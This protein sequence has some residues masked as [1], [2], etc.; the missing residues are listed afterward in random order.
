LPTVI[1]QF[2]RAASIDS[3]DAGVDIASKAANRMNLAETIGNEDMTYLKMNEGADLTE[4]YLQAVQ[5]RQH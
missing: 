3:A 2:S 5:S 1:L 4:K